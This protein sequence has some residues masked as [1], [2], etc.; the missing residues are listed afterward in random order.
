MG[1]I[2]DSIFFG[3]NPEKGTF[4][5]V[6]K[7]DAYAAALTALGREFVI[8][9]GSSLCTFRH[10]DGNGPLPGPHRDADGAFALAA[11][12]PRLS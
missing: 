12:S 11:R 3:G 1:E 5:T 9:P 2:M 10:T 4:C 6:E 8:S 7:A